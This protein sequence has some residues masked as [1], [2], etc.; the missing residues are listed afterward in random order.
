MKNR[1]VVVLL[2]LL[3][4]ACRALPAEWTDTERAQIEAD[5]EQIVVGLYGAIGRAD[6]GPWMA[7]LHPETG[8]WLWGSEFLDLRGGSEAFEAAWSSESDTRLSRQEIDDL[9]VRVVAVSPTVAYALCTSTER[10]S[11]LADGTID[12][13]SS[14]E[15]WVFVLTDVGWRMYAGQT[16]LSPIPDDPVNE[17]G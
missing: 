14:A 10:R 9:E 17:S 8:P 12:R 15:T 4:S 2:C 1:T 7:T 13:F 16:V 5:V 6:V 3:V 11:Y